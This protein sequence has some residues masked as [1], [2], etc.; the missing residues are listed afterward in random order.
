MSLFGT[1]KTYCSIH[2]PFIGKWVLICLLL[3]ICIGSAS[4]GFLVSLDWVTNFR[5]THLWI[6]YFLPLV[7]FVVSWVY[8]K[9]GKEVE[10]G[11]NLIIANIQQPQKVIPFRMSPMI[12]LATLATHLFGGSAGREGTALQMAAGI[13]DR[14]VKP[15]SL[16]E[17]ERRMLLI[18]AIAAGFAAVFGTPLAGAVFG[19]EVARLGKVDYKA[20]LPAFFSAIIADAVVTKFWLVGHTHY[21]IGEIPPLNAIN[22]LY[23]IFAGICFGICAKLFSLSMSYLGAWGKKN[24]EYAP[25]RAASGAIVVLLLVWLL[26][27][28]KYLGLGIP[29]IE[30]SFQTHLPFYD[31]IAKFI[32][33]VITLSVGFKGGEVTPLFFIG[34]TLG[35]ALSF[36]VPLPIGLMAGMGFV[37]VF[38]GAANTPLACILMA[39]ELFGG[40]C[41]VYAAIACVVAYVVSGQTSIYKQQLV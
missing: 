37:A 23:A 4:A 7:G 27:T 11:N 41:G 22:I 21:L 31:F 29:T 26:G 32:L 36:F 14:L 30:A 18:S 9:Y 16:D 20:L 1:F 6:I 5:E 34:A 40:Q 38:A 8:Q 28:D 12:Y 2:L 3:S 15:F 17:E 13:A 10:A 33:T 24:I 25:L 35:N 19:L 39:V